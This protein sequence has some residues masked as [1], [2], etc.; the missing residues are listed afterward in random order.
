MTTSETTARIEAINHHPSGVSRI[1][2]SLRGPFRHNSGQY[3]NIVH[4]S[5]A[6]IP[7]SIASA[8]DRLPQIE[9]HY[10]STP[11]LAEAALVDE[12]LDQ[13]QRAIAIDG[14]HGNVC[15]DAPT[16]SEL[17]LF[18]G[19]T[20]IAQAFGIIE[21]L[22]GVPQREAVHLIWSVADRTQLYCD[23]ELAN[24]PQWLDVRVLIDHPATGNAAVHWLEKQRET[25]PRGRIILC[26]GPGFVHAV[27]D[28]LT[29][30]G[31]PGN[32]LES[33][34]FGYAPRDRD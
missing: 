2:L 34:V 4:P 26:G 1:V 16:A 19:G 12:L 8:P 24:G 23:A 15:V 28:A 29:G 22:R 5:G 6:R 14:P 25:P 33:D 13:P 10:R 11:G 32:A 30:L 3:L 31:V 21:H 27:A 9:L 7:L 20:G 18:A 17:W